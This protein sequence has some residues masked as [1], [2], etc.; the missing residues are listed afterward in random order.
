MCILARSSCIIL[1]L[2]SYDSMYPD[3]HTYRAYI[4]DTSGNLSVSYV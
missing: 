4:G 1:Q 2:N 3:N